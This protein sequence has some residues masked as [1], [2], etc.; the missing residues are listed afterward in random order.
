MNIIWPLKQLWSF[1]N[2]SPHSPDQWL[3]G[4]FC[5][6]LVKIQKSKGTGD[7]ALVLC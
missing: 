7:V 3:G 4:R 5:F 1:D 2:F 6:L